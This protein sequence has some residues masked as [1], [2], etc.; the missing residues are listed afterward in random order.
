[1]IKAW[2]RRFGGLA[3]VATLAACS[4]SEPT[5]PN[6]APV[7]VPAQLNGV[8]AAQLMDAI[9]KAGLPAPNRRDTTA[10][11][12]PQLQCVQSI[13]TDTVSV[14]K[15][16]GTGRAQLYAAAI[17]NVYQVEDVVLTFAPTVTAELKQ[18]YERAVDRAAF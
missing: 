14:L 13:E 3:A 6:T 11:K 9:V 16:P 7:Q 4:H 15:F 8:S 5:T 10:V 12:C 17:S 1:M 18:D 2:A